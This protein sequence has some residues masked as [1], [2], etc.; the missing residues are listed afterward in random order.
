MLLA[1]AATLAALY[2]IEMRRKPSQA[3]IATNITLITI[4]LQQSDASIVHRLRAERPFQQS[5]S[6]SNAHPTV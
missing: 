2:T 5:G 1:T 4:G 6:P 3:F